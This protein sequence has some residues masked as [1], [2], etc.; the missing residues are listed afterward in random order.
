M[1]DILSNIFFWRLAKC[2]VIQLL[3][4]VVIRNGYKLADWIFEFNNKK[5]ISG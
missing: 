1:I 3:L 2:G 4:V 5:R